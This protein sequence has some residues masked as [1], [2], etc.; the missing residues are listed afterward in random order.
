MCCGLQDTQP[1]QVIVSGGNS[2][3]RM[4]VLGKAEL[5]KYTGW[6]SWRCDSLL[7][8]R[9]IRPDPQT[10]A[11][12][13]RFLHFKIATVHG[14]GHETRIRAL[15]V[16]GP[17]RAV[18]L[19]V[20]SERALEERLQTKA[21]DVFK[22][23]FGRCFFAGDTRPA[24]AAAAAPA[25]PAVTAGAAAAVPEAKAKPPAEVAAVAADQAGDE[26]KKLEAAAPVAAAAAAAAAPAAAQKEG[27]ADEKEPAPKKEEALEVK[28]AAAAAADGKKE[29]DKKAEVAAP[30]A[31]SGGGAAPQLKRTE[32]VDVAA[33]NVVGVLFG[34]DKSK[35]AEVMIA[36]MSGVLTAHLFVLC[37]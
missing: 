29:E 11:L 36:L 6:Y 24:S 21:L 27:A 30:A 1:R 26:K 5:P 31:V 7:S 12:R 32:S 14:V 37:V 20:E 19:S 33:P 18:P 35:P 28:A 23:L 15:K 8:G 10:G 9:T 4:E 2:R 17:G 25:A 13:V 3:D 22:A 34:D 16:Y